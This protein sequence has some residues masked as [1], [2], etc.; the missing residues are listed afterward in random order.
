MDDCGMKLDLAVGYDQKYMYFWYDKW[1]LLLAA[2]D[3]LQGTYEE[4]L[5]MTNLSRQGSY[6]FGVQR[7]CSDKDETGKE[8]ILLS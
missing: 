3:N 7:P 4:G 6:S 5:G 2:E 1:Y 8:W